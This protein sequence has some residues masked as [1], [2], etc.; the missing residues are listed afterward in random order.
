MSVLQETK[1]LYFVIPSRKKTSFHAKFQA[2]CLHCLPVFDSYN[3]H[4]SK[5]A[6]KKITCL[7][8][9]SDEDLLTSSPVLLQLLSCF[10]KNWQIFD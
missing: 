4:R 10:F 9:S 6:N 1:E 8:T 3:K 5:R 7:Y 2:C